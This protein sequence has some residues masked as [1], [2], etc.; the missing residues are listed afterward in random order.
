MEKVEVESHDQGVITRP[1]LERDTKEIFN[2]LGNSKEEHTYA[3]TTNT[4]TWW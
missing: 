3:L 2:F 1:G 4:G